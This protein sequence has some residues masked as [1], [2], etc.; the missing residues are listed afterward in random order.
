MLD[1][2]DA[3][4]VCDAAKELVKNTPA[5]VKEVRELYSIE[6]PLIF[7]GVVNVDIR[8]HLWKLR[9]LLKQD[10]NCL[11]GR[12]SYGTRFDITAVSEDGKHCTALTDYSCGYNQ[13]TSATVTLNE[14]HISGNLD[15]AIID[16]KYIIKGNYTVKLDPEEQIKAETEQRDRLLQIQQRTQQRK[17]AIDNLVIRELVSIETH[18]SNTGV[19]SDYK[20]A[21][22]KES[23]NKKS[24]PVYGWWDGE[25]KFDNGITFSNQTATMDNLPDFVI[26]SVN[27]DLNTI[28]LGVFNPIDLDTDLYY[29]GTAFAYLESSTVAN[30]EIEIMGA[31]LMDRKP[32]VEFA[33]EYDRQQDILKGL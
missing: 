19:A 2:K 8:L 28:T 5:E 30:K 14:R 7:D 27:K 10:D 12:C 4:E 15:K 16:N 11:K 9:E 22:L 32:F 6:L 13:L 29:L 33:K 23:V 31:Y 17:D 24:S 25:K 21:A 18:I 1:M 20:W 3:I 26:T